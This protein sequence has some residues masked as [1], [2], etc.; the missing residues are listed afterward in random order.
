M[1]NSD[2][3]LDSLV[4]Q[5]V[6][7]SNEVEHDEDFDNTQRLEVYRQ[8]KANFKQAIQAHIDRLVIQ[9]KVDELLNFTNRCDQ[10]LLDRQWVQVR[11]VELNKQLEERI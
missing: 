5:F 4:E 7:D 1:T 2:G 6:E 10:L 3:W 11:I 8:V 9:A